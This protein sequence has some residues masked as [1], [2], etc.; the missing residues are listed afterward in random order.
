MMRVFIAQKYRSFSAQS[1]S[2]TARAG[3]R[4][5]TGSPERGDEAEILE[6]EAGAD[7]GHERPDAGCAR[8][9][10]CR[11]ATPVVR[12]LVRGAE[13]RVVDRG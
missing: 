2:G 12:A 11:P 6:I 3:R 10:R 5:G 9:P 8:P 1:K 4:S 13:R 7:A